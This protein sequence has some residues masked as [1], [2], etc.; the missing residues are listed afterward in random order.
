MVDLGGTDDGSGIRQYR[1]RIET[2]LG[3]VGEV[4]HRA[5]EA[6]IQPS[7]E[8]WAMRVRLRTRNPDGV[9]TQIASHRL[10]SL[11][12][13]LTWMVVRSGHLAEGHPHGLLEAGQSDNGLVHRLQMTEGR[14]RPRQLGVGELDASDDAVFE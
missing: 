6:T 8:E 4:P 14:L 1:T 2:S 7:S 10:E 11:C 3:V 9:Q 12:R 13:G 5:V